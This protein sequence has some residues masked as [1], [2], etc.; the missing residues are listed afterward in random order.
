MAMPEEMKAMYENNACPV[1]P[2]EPP[3]EQCCGNG[4]EVC[5]YDTYNAQL[6]QYYK[7]KAAWD[8]LQANQEKSGA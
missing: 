2:I 8:A 4:C 1:A 7:D 5:I 3:A 6:R